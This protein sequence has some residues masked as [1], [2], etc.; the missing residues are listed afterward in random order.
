MATATAECAAP[1]HSDPH[2]VTCDGLNR[3][4]APAPVPLVTL[5]IGC[6]PEVE[7]AT[8]SGTHACPYSESF[9]LDVAVPVSASVEGDEIWTST[10]TTTVGSGCA[11]RLS[12]PSDG[13]VQATSAP[14]ASYFYVGASGD[15][16]PLTDTTRVPVGRATVIARARNYLDAEADIVVRADRSSSASLV[17]EPRLIASARCTGPDHEAA[18][19]ACLPAPPEECGV[20]YDGVVTVTNT[21]VT[22]EGVAGSEGGPLA[23]DA[24]AE[25]LR[26][27]IEG[28][29]AR[30]I[31]AECVV[32]LR[33]HSASPPL[34]GPN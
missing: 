9:A 33:S 1:T 2:P 19:L 12:I 15:E 3:V 8:P 20:R 23:D 32:E 7:V 22:V 27:Q 14:P 34:F 6:A 21:Q 30:P 24:C 16:V 29:V 25:W 26:T 28:C 31:S 18:I 11:I 17:L 4:T 10:T 13:V 5:T